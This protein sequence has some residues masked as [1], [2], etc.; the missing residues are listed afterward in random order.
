MEVACAGTR[1]VWIPVRQKWLSSYGSVSLHISRNSKVSV[2]DPR[3]AC[4]EALREQDHTEHLR[5]LIG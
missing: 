5:A 4:M 1:P 3:D 2:G